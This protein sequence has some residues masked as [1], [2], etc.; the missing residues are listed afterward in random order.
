MKDYIKINFD[1]ICFIMPTKSTAIRLFLKNRTH[2][3]LANLYSL[4]M[5]CQVNVAQNGGERIGGE[6]KGKSWQGWTDGLTTWKSFR[7]PYKAKTNPEYIDRRI[8][9]DLEKHVEAIGMT[10]WDWKNRVSKWLA[11]DFDAIINHSDG[12][13][14]KEL[15]E[16]Q[17]AAFKL[18]WVT[19]RKSTSGKGFHLYVFVNNIPTQNHNEHAALAR[20]ILGQMSAVT[21]FNFQAKVDVCGSNMWVWHRKMKGTDGLTLIKQGTILKDIPLQWKDHLK[22]IQGINQK[23]LPSEIIERDNIDVFEE[24]TSQN[25]KIKLDKDHKKLI[26]YL[27]EINARAWWDSDNHMLVTHTVH[28]KQAFEDLQLKGYFNTIST[29]KDLGHDHNVYLFPMRKGAWSVRRYTPGVKEHSSWHQDGSGWTKCYLNRD[30]DF[31]TACKSLGSI[32][33]P[34]GGFIFQEAEIAIQAARLLGVSLDIDPRYRLREAK[35]KQNKEKKLI[36][37]IERKASDTA[38]KMPGWL[39]KSN[40]PWTKVYQPKTEPNQEIEHTNFDDVI[41][42]LITT[43]QEDCGWVIKSEKIWR[44]EPLI[45]IKHALTTLGLNSKEIAAVLGSSILRPWKTVNKPFE[46]EYPGGRKWNRKGAQFRFL[47]SKSEVLSYPTWIKILE[48]CGSG[49]NDDLKNNKWAKSNGILTGADYLKCWIASMFRDPFEPVAYLFF[50]GQQG[51]G[52]SIFHEA[53]SLLFTK[54]YTRAEAAITGQSGFNAELEGSILCA[55]EEINLQKNQAAYNKIKDWVT[56]KQI[57]IHPKYITPY[58]VKNSS[59]WVQMSNDYKSCPIF[60]GDTRITML[61][62]EPLKPEEIIPKKLIFQKLEK[63]APDFLAEILR[64]DLPNPDNRM[65]IPPIETSDKVAVQIYNQT[66]LEAFIQEKCRPILGA[67]IKFSDF[68]QQF[69]TWID[70]Q[71]AGEWSKIR[72]GKEIPPHFPK[73]RRSQ[74]GQMYIGNIAWINSD[75]E[76]GEKLVIRNGYLE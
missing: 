14:A 75:I 69:L 76:E 37:E 3:D 45:H 19:I 65:N 43:N 4:E 59:H 15:E 27:K 23:V 25:I 30:L 66:D 42:H 18:D 2:P 10:G 16:V 1:L 35:L 20:A 58:L 47:P 62:V 46:P 57:L 40:K 21:G 32:E 12:L 5:E 13:T 8:S 64:I 72:V 38:E 74:D 71:D 26:E 54:G 67:M 39:A 11:Y 9:F 73:A 53:L 24:L 52:K 28:L 49:L 22:V 48:H 60:P 51:S 29:G 56:S 36:V 34:K 17:Q 7:I 63:E 61:Y 70:S 6:Y 33:D 41:R 31:A 50:W 55:I 68:Y 44:S